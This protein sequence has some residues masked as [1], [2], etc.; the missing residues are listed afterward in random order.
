MG[1]K[2]RQK[3]PSNTSGQPLP[4]ENPEQNA[5]TEDTSQMTEKEEPNYD[6]MLAE[7]RGVK[8]H[9]GT[10]PDNRSLIEKVFIIL[11]HPFSSLLTN[12]KFNLELSLQKLSGEDADTREYACNALAN[13]VSDSANETLPLLRTKDVI[14]ILLQNVRSYSSILLL[15]RCSSCSILYFQFELQQLAFSAMFQLWVVSSIVNFSSNTIF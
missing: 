12:S 4:V 3:K 13:L 1:K 10:A 8:Y 7:P 14:R 15:T 2:N 6:R 5:S 11:D 9:E